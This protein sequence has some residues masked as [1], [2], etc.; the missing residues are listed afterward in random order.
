MLAKVYLGLLLISATFAFTSP[1][2][3]SDP[4]I[5]V[6]KAE[7]I[8]TDI[9]NEN[10]VDVR[11]RGEYAVMHISGA[12]NIPSYEI[13][14]DNLSNLVQTTHKDKIIFYCSRPSCPMSRSAV[15][16]AIKLGFRNVFAY[17][18]GIYDWAVRFPDNTTFLEQ[19][20]TREKLPFLE[21]LSS[22]I[23]N[24]IVTPQKFESL[25]QEGYV[26]VDL[27]PRALMNP[28]KVG[29]G[30]VIY[31]SSERIFESQKGGLPHDFPQQKFLLFDEDGSSSYGAYHY[32]RNK[33]ITDFFFIMHGESDLRQ[34]HSSLLE[35]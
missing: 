22:E 25:L 27:R 16:N 8:I 10:I 20:L 3:L 19:P 34:A 33:G 14:Y 26:V 2:L 21:K 9:F 13:N 35:K 7:D 1:D 11:S 32:L 28:L 12:V 29:Q 24:Y 4:S 23:S 15:K 31:Y 5:A 17:E 6:V 30:K 18:N